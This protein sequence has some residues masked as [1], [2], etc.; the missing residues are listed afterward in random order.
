[1]PITKQARLEKVQRLL[2]A[3]GRTKKALESEP[4]VHELHLGTDI[5]QNWP[6]ITAAYSGLEQTIKYLIAEQRGLTIQ[7]LVDFAVEDDGEWHGRRQRTNPYRTHNLGRLFSELD[8]VTKDTVSEFYRRYHSLVPYIGIGSVDQFLHRVSGRRGDGYVRWRYALIEEKPLPS[9]SPQALVAI[10]GV[11]VQIAQEKD[12][13]YPQVQMPDNELGEELCSHLEMLLRRVFNE[14]HDPGEPL[15]DIEGEVSAWFRETGHPLNPLAEAL[16]HF[17]RYGH[18]GVVDVPPWF[19]E[20]LT[21]WAREVVDQVAR[22]GPTLLR[23]FLVSAQGHTRRGKSVRW[24]PERKRFES[25]PWSLGKRF[26][27]TPPEGE[28]VID[29]RRAGYEAPLRSLWAAAEEA[30]YQVRENRAFAGPPDQDPWFCTLEVT[31]ENAERVLSMWQQML[32]LHDDRFHMVVECDPESMG[33]PVRRWIDL[34][35][36]LGAI[37]RA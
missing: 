26:L 31:N 36:R 9:N 14:M 25:V 19:L 3:H 24:N 15:R 2:T 1:M 16:W 17:A 35:R 18:A 30:G 12:W 5:A 33:E 21:R 22:A 13:R 23:A 34:A 27:D 28:I 6:V 4:V 20:A 11:C 8:Q 29:H 32:N 10:W 37:R 7:E